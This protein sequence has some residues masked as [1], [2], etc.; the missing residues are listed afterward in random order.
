MALQ[1]AIAVPIIPIRTDGTDS[2]QAFVFLESF[3]RAAL[4]N[5]WNS[6]IKVRQIGIYLDGLALAWYSNNFE[7]VVVQDFQSTWHSIRTQFL[8]QICNSNQLE[9]DATYKLHS[10]EKRTTETFRTYYYDCIYFLKY[11]SY[12]NEM[13]VITQ[14]LHGLPEHIQLM[15]AVN[16]PITLNALEK[17]CI[18]FDEITVLNKPSKIFVSSHESEAVLTVI[19]NAS[20]T[21]SS[22]I[23]PIND[24]NNDKR[25]KKQRPRC[26]KCKQKGHIAK[27]CSSTN[28]VRQS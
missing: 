11:L 7:K 3:E 14:I 12:F 1:K 18:Q 21:I 27:E 20:S 6:E 22:T 5:K 15:I 16:R 19:P 2:R 26:I 13:N 10:L 28:S 9:L 25:K 23:T 8:L 17:L 24:C 4:A